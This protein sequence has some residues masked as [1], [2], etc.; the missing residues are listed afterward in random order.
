M[1]FQMRTVDPTI[2]FLIVAGILYFLIVGA[3]LMRRTLREWVVGLL[4]LYTAVSFLWTLGQVFLRLGWLAFP[5]ADVLARVPLYG[6]PLLSLLFLH[7]SR[8][9]LRLEG[10]GLGWWTLGAAW[11]VAVV[12]L[13]ENLLA[14]PEV[15]WI[16]N[17]WVIHRQ[18]LDFC[19]LVFGWGV[20]MGGA[21]LL[22]ARAYRRTQRPLHRN[23]ITYWSLALA[24]TVAGA[25]LLLAGQELFSSGFYLL[26][27]LSAAYV[28]LTYRL[29]DVRQMARRTMSY[30]IIT[31]LT[32]AIYTAGFLVT[33]YAFQ[34]VPG[35]SPV[36]AGAAMALV[37]AILFDPLLSLVQRLVNRLISG[38]GYDPS[39]TLREYSA[40]ISNILDLQRLAT[41]AVNLI[42]K[43][44]KIRRGALFVVHYEKGESG[45]DGNSYFHLRSVT[46]MGEDLPSGVLSADSPVAD[47][48]RQEHHPL[49]QY[50]IDLLPRFQ[51]ISAAERIWLASLNMDVYVPI[52]A[53]GEWIG[54]LALGPKASGDRYFD[55]DLMLL[56]TLADQTA[57]ALENARLF[58]D[59]KI[60]T[61][62]IER[63]NRE[64]ATANRELARL[65]Q[66]KSDFIN[67]ASHEL[68]TPLS[69]VLGYNDILDEMIKDGSP[70]SG[71]AL[72]L[73]EG[74]RKAVQRLREIVNTMFDI[75]QI[76]TE[77]LVLELFPASVAL[78][79]SAAVNTWAAALEER[80]QTLTVE[81]LANL[82]TIF[83]DS[84]RLEQAFSHLVQNAIKF[85]PDG[86]Y[87]RITGR[88]MGEEMPPQ[89]QAIEVG[90]ADNGIGIAPDDLEYVFEKF[91]RAGD[92]M[93][94]STGRTKFKGAGP[95]LGL[96]IARG[97]VEAHG[98]RIWAESPG[99]DEETC[100]GSEFHVV[101]PVQPRHL[102]SASSEA[103]IAAVRATT[104]QASSTV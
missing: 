54:L 3:V 39:R 31:L 69:Q 84:K 35:Y 63:L 88:L 46:G 77:T 11:I 91:Y 71:S 98:G 13:S 53:K 95:G 62:E 30:L 47:Y 12:V 23:R 59:L 36:L 68:R 67:I 81:G 104:D 4:V 78:I 99:C 20:F 79:V 49:T 82:P 64:L 52:Y 42:S 72:Q 75:S 61:A 38:T 76:D 43:A 48:L 10:A 17:G 100:P 18:G 33:Q 21:T 27:T 56:S 44:M 9:F 102:E 7:L 5:T 26:G 65:D 103:F 1:S 57:V 55:D 37:L 15:L 32:V 93:L 25:A 19:V 6:I 41:V 96:T 66:A 80:K 60:R 70:I 83:A 73:T 22:T 14:L 87:I 45:E 89:D 34:T 92:V 8:S 28:V 58:D 50:D 16:S 97:V 101:L 86:G 85:T 24:F 40:S 29:P 94:H 51:A 74:V 90:V 2:I